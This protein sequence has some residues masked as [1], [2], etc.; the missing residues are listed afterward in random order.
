MTKTAAI[1]HRWWLAA[2]PAAG[3]VASCDD[4][5]RR[6]IWRTRDLLTSW[7]LYG[8][9]KWVNLRQIGQTRDRG[10][11]TSDVMVRFN[12]IAST[13]ETLVARLSKSRPAPQFVTNGADWKIRR[14]TEKLNKFGKGVL[15]SSRF[16]DQLDGF[17]RECL[18]AGT[19]LVKFCIDEHAKKIRAERVMPWEIFVPPWEAE[20][21]VPRTLMQRT[22]VD[23]EALREAWGTG[24]G[25]TKR[26]AAIDASASSA[27]VRDASVGRFEEG[28]DMVD[29]YEGWHLGCD[30][31]PGRHVIAVSGGLLLDEPWKPERW[32]FAVMTWDEP[33][34]GFWGV[35]V[36]SH[37]ESVQYEINNLLQ[38]VQVSIHLHAHPPTFIDSQSD[39]PP[40]HITNE[41]G[42]IIKLPPG[43]SPPTR[44]VVPIMSP[45]VY[46]HIET[47]KQSVY[48]REG[49][50][51]M[52]ATG[53]KPAGL[54]AAVAMREY[55]DTMSERHM[56]QGRKLEKFAIDA[57]EVCL[58]LAEMIP[59]FEVDT[60]DRKTNERLKWSDIKVARDAFV[61]QVFPVASL[62][63]SP[64]ARKQYVSELAQAGWI[65]PQKAMAL[66]DMPDLEE[67][68]D[69]TNAALN[70]IRSQV[71]KILDGA[72]AMAPEP[73]ANL[74]QALE[75]SVGVLLRETANGAPEDVLEQLRR[76]VAQLEK[77]A[78]NAAQ[79]MQAAQA[80]PPSAQMPA[81]PQPVM[82]APPIA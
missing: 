59:G 71:E 3:L 66:L 65:T 56:V 55:N 76:Y 82:A 74:P 72:K 77:T 70:V 34:N 6:E 35:G 32:P 5:A 78:A 47:L 26:L 24:D 64:P 43:S 15:H 10:L 28:A 41:A 68:S 49:V 19:C 48:E 7:R 53:V 38:K 36:P 2:E 11:S 13:V 57:V 54:D 20:R 12:A 17:V 8:G 67:D 30:G 63:Q 80:P 44:V 31:G 42:A 62:P 52:A 1:N 73:R 61:L 27:D 40:A 45:E 50:S 22:P 16:Y 21:G 14:Q 51:M 25:K 9:R 33:P 60:M 23:R 81:P 46:Q 69:N 39:V 29:V 37:N 75:Y 18:V 58:D 4:I 79:A